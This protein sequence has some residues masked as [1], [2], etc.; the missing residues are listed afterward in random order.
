MSNELDLKSLMNVSGLGLTLSLYGE[1]DEEETV[2]H[3]PLV[4]IDVQSS[5]DLEQRESDLK[6]DYETARQNI[7]FQQQMILDMAKIALENAK[8]SESPRF[9]DSFTALMS[10][11][12]KTNAD[13]I[14]IHQEL[15][16]AMGK[17]VSIKKGAD[18]A[19]TGNLTVNGTATVFVGTPQ[20]L[21]QRE[22]DAVEGEYDEIG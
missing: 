11:M 5:S 22:Q 21:M 2:T 20:E 18:K 4:L 10:Q 7:H 6:K 12:G 14:K 9:V 3:E 19:P 1:N 16:K 8:N 15:N 13:L 17:D